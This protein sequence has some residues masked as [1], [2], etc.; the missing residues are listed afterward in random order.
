MEMQVQVW[1][2]NRRQRVRLQGLRTDED[3]S[4]EGEGEG[5]GGADEQRE[6]YSQQVT[7]TS[8]AIAGNKAAFAPEVATETVAVDATVVEVLP[9]STHEESRRRSPPLVG[10]PKAA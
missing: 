10:C 2:R 6:A 7:V 4:E 5:A 1:F 9:E 8:D 3:D